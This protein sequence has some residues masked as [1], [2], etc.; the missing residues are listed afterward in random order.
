MAIE[1]A[2]RGSGPG[3][4]RIVRRSVDRHADWLRDLEQ[5]IGEA[6][7]SGDT[8]ALD[9][10]RPELERATRSVEALTKAHGRVRNREKIT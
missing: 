3:L 6:E 1:T 8:E 4:R 9:R 5:R 7:S 2:T 10:L